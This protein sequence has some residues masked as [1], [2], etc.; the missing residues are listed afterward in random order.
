MLTEEHFHRVLSGLIFIGSTAG[1]MYGEEDG[2]VN[3]V[4][5]RKKGSNRK[6]P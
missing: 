4:R 1:M 3:I 2:G 6:R 5:R